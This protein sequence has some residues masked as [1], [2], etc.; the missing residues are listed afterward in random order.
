MATTCFRRHSRPVSLAGSFACVSACAC[1]VGALPPRRF[2]LEPCSDAGLNRVLRLSTA[3][4]QS[5]G[6]SPW[7]S[8][9]P[10]QSQDANGQSQDGNVDCVCSKG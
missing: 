5:N 1:A 10:L 8:Q 2:R 4:S 9:A 7:H 6:E 3:S